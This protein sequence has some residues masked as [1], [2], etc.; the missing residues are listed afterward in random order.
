M[1]HVGTRLGDGLFVPGVGRLVGFGGRVLGV[2]EVRVPAPGQVLDGH[3]VPGLVARLA[4]GDAALLVLVRA[5]RPVVPDVDL[6]VAGAQEDV[7]LL[8]FAL[9]VVVLLESGGGQR[10]G[11]GVGVERGGAGIDAGLMERVPHERG[12]VDVRVE[13]PVPLVV[14]VR[15]VGGDLL[16]LLDPRVVGAVG[17]RVPLLGELPPAHG[18]DGG[19]H[20]VSGVAGHVC[21]RH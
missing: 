12:A 9:V 8:D 2:P 3:L 20:G 11:L 7:A 14:A 17:R 15:V 1:V 6:G 21:R 4:S 5:D 10:G 16:A 18:D 19:V 13:P